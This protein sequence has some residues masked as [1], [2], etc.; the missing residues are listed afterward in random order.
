[1]ENQK[2][3]LLTTLKKIFTSIN[4]ASVGTLRD[5]KFKDLLTGIKN[6]VEE[7]GVEDVEIKII[8]H[9]KL[10]SKLPSNSISYEV[11]NSLKRE[12]TITDTLFP[13]CIEIKYPN[14]SYFI[15][16]ISFDKINIDNLL[17]PIIKGSKFEGENYLE[18]LKEKQKKDGE[19]LKN[20][21]SFV[22]EKRISI[23]IDDIVPIIE[24]KTENEYKEIRYK[25]NEEKKT[26]FKEKMKK[27]IQDTDL[28]KKW[29]ELDDFASNLNFFTENFE[30]LLIFKECQNIEKKK[31][32]SYL[33]NSI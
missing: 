23:I 19:I 31:K 26:N 13:E 27:I 7:K 24:N 21:V 10:D 9:N 6:G 20:Q 30:T 2:N 18:Y 25:D 22:K 16:G 4:N 29:N 28:N 33:N 14:T 8:D 3:N 15:Y 17:E 1:M 5:T 12:V 32:R 11:E